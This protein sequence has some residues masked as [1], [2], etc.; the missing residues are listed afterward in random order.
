MSRKF[1]MFFAVAF[2]SAF[3]A[4]ACGIMEQE[5]QEGREQVEQEVQ[6]GRTQVEQEIQKG[7]TQIAEEIEGQ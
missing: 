6:E 1:A 7:R 2:V 4:A 3:G 5:I